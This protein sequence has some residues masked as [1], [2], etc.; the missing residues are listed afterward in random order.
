MEMS[1]EKCLMI[2][3]IGTKFE[4][5]LLFCFKNDKNLVNFDRNNKKSK[6]FALWLVPFVQ[7]IQPL[8]KTVQWSYIS[9]HWRVLQNLKK[10]WFGVWKMKNL[11][12]FHQN[13]S[14]CQNWYF[15]G[16]VLSKVE[17]ALATTYRGWK[18]HWRM[19]KNLKTNWLIVS[20]VP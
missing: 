6:K 4:E 19:I 12:N 18:W 1:H 17:N 7:S 8:T 20:K 9:W 13:T 15:H 5:K 16:I 14:K 2:P 11:T 10:N 3:K